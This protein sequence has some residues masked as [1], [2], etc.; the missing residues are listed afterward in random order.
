MSNNYWTFGEV[1]KL[2]GASSKAIRYYLDNGLIK[3][4]KKSSGGYRLFDS[5][6]I[7]LIKRILFLKDLGFPIKKIHQILHYNGDK[8]DIEQQIQNKKIEMEKALEALNHTIIIQAL[9]DRY[10]R[11]FIKN[12]SPQELLRTAADDAFDIFNVASKDAIKKIS[13]FLDK[14]EPQQREKISRAVNMIV[15][16]FI[17]LFEES[18]VDHTSSSVEKIMDE[19]FNLY[20]EFLTEQDAREILLLE[21]QIWSQSYSRDNFMDIDPK[22]RMYIGNCFLYWVTKKIA[23]RM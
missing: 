10:P 21:A 12:K 15:K 22:V 5:I 11:D 1:C 9:L 4:S 3:Y 19:V 6:Q 20:F 8:N 13:E 16:N 2:T 23:P 7:G 18:Q 14:L 17:D